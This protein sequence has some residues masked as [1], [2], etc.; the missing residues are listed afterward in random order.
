MIRCNI[1]FLIDFKL[2]GRGIIDVRNISKEWYDDRKAI[3]SDMKNWCQTNIGLEEGYPNWEFQLGK[4]YPDA[5][6]RGSMLGLPD[7][8][9]ITIA[10]GVFIFDGAA[11]VA[12]KLRYGV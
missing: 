12:F 3:E 2:Q 11:R 8:M 1:R 6:V 10:Y 9:T 7:T 5:Y 4:L